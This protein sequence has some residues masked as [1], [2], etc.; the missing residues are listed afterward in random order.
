MRAGVFF[1]F[2]AVVKK[3]YYLCGDKTLCRGF[4]AADEAAGIKRESGENPVQYPLL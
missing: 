2:V 4:V 1:I 3:M